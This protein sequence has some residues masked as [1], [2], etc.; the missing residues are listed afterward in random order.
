LK[1]KPQ[2]R[3]QIKKKP[4]KSRAIT[5]K[6]HPQQQAMAVYKNHRPVQLTEHQIDLIKRLC[7]RDATPDEFELFLTI[8][9]RSRLDPFKKEIYCII[10]S[11]DDPKKR[12]MVL[13]TGIDGFRSMA[14]RDHKD[15]GGTSAASY[16]WFDPPMKTPRAGKLIP[17]TATVTAYR[18]GGTTATATAYWEEF[19]PA[20]MTTDR[21][22][23]W[24]RM[25]KL[26]L[27]KCAEARALRK[28]FP[29]L[30][31]IFTHEEMDQSMQDLSPE[32]RQIHEDGVAPSGAIVDQYAMAKAAQQHVLDEKLPHGH[33]PGSPQAKQAEAALRRVEEE[34]ARLAAAKP[35]EAKR[36]PEKPKAAPKSPMAGCTLVSGN[37]VRVVQSK[38]ANGAAVMDLQIGNTHYKCFHRSLFTRLQEFGVMGGFVIQAF[39]DQR[40]TVAGLKKL[41][42]IF[43]QPDGKT[44]VEVGREPG[45][46]G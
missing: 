36:E 18:K 24:R 38:A 45:S 10:F 12:Q 33:A 7:A 29:G 34:D 46:D 25:P 2:H 3:K 4:S 15:F 40:G 28:C 44:E 39:I 43:Y 26:M 13:I 23:F 31:N 21:A 6:P 16:T 32:G 20:D 9:K 22:D 30:G 42:P 19:A 5:R 17:E 11:K 41:G 27:E 35:V 8:C 1:R 37:L 14:A